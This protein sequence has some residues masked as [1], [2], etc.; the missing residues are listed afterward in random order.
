MFTSNDIFA[1]AAS[2][3]YQLKYWGFLCWLY[4]TL[5]LYLVSLV[6]NCNYIIN[7]WNEPLHSIDA[8]ELHQWNTEHYTGFRIIFMEKGLWF[9][10][11][12]PVRVHLQKNIHCNCRLGDS[13]DLQIKGVLYH[14]QTSLA[15]GQPVSLVVVYICRTHSP[16][17]RIFTDCRHPLQIN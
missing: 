4:N 17:S 3:L 1:L 2:C 12:K 13:I 14:M 16:F 15:S 6:V 11:L 5:N 7:C 9:L 10:D 8:L